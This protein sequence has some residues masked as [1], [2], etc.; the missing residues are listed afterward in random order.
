MIKFKIE[1]REFKIGE[2]KIKDYY[3]IEDL[4]TLAERM[5]SKLKI[6]SQLSGA[7]EAL[8]RKMSAESIE[9]LW[10]EIAAGPLA[11]GAGTFQHI[12]EINGKEYGFLDV[13]KLTVGEMADMDTLRNHVNSSKQL[14]KMM[15]VLWRPLIQKEPKMQIE[16]HTSDGFEARAEEF[17]HHMPIQTVLRST[18]FFFHITKAS[19]ENM[20]DSLAADL[21]TEMKMENLQKEAKEK[22]SLLQDNGQNSFT[23]WLVTI[24]LKLRKLRGSLSSQRL[25]ILPTEKTKQRKKSSNTKSFKNNIEND[26]Y[27]RI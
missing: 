13:T 25:T 5:D 27:N 2:P 11:N 7:N 8:I 26:N 10:L 15:A 20:M 21:K 14:H 4:L 19:F 18:S 9:K 17:L 12:I 24:Y 22:I 23:S 3:K 6:I 1:E 16:E